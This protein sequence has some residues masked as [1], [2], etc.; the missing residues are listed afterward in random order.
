MSQSP[1]TDNAEVA[2][3]ITIHPPP[4]EVELA[5]IVAAVALSVSGQ[6]DQGN[7]LTLVEPQ[8]RWAAA[9]R[10]EAM[11]SDDTGY[12]LRSWEWRGVR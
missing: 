2:P 6:P 12:R 1:V 11:S 9:G 8:S 10:R 3:S 4:T 5:A 7:A